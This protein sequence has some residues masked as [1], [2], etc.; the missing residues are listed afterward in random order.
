MWHL[1]QRTFVMRIMYYIFLQVRTIMYYICTIFSQSKLTGHP[2]SQTL[3]KH[4]PL[5]FVCMVARF[6]G[7]ILSKSTQMSKS[8]RSNACILS[9]TS[10]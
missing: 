4:L 10:V 3:V 2:D 5:L 9:G 1:P 8:M 7:T 6:W